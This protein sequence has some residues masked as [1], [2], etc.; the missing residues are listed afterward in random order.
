MELFLIDNKSA[1]IKLS[2]ISCHNQKIKF[3]AIST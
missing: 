1:K 2:L 3:Y